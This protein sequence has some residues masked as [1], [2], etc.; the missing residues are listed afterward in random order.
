MDLFSQYLHV[1][2]SVC[3]RLPI[4]SIHWDLAT[5]I[6]TFPFP[7]QGRN[8]TRQDSLSWCWVFLWPDQRTWTFLKE[9]SANIIESSNKCGKVHPMTCLF[10]PIISQTN[11]SHSSKTIS[12][13]QMHHQKMQHLHKDWWWSATHCG[14]LDKDNAVSTKLLLCHWYHFVWLCWKEGNK[15]WR[16]RT[17]DEEDDTAHWPY[18]FVFAS[19]YTDLK[20]ENSVIQSFFRLRSR[21]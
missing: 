20:V 3:I 7:S 4:A 11:P 12:W 2:K 6:A 15:R 19:N 13:A 16:E 5:S 8:E 14:N 1:S 9:K 18:V 10:G 21:I 17:E